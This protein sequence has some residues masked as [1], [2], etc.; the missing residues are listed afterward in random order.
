[1]TEIVKP[2]A[3]ADEFEV[4]A[5]E[6]QKIGDELVK[7]KVR[8]ATE[9]IYIRAREGVKSDKQAER[10][11]DSTEDGIKEMTYSFQRKGMEKLMQAINAKLRVLDGERYNR[12]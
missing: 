10:I 4:M 5:R 7:I 3:L 11:W 6:Y 12:Y 2:M 8:K 1:M 9:M